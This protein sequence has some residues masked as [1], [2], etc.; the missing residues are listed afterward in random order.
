MEKGG[1]K[2]TTQAWYKTAQEPE[3]YFHGTTPEFTGF[4]TPSLRDYGH[5][6]IYFS[7]IKENG[8]TQAEYIA[9]GP[10]GGKLI[11]AKIDF[12]ILK[13]FDPRNDIRSA[14]I[15]REIGLKENFTTNEKEQVFTDYVEYPDMGD[16]APAA[17]KEGY[18]LFRVREPSVQGFS[19]AV[20]DENAIEII[21]DT[22]EMDDQLSIM[23][24]KEKDFL[25]KEAQAQLMSEKL[26]GEN[27]PDEYEIMER[28]EDLFDKY[29]MAQV[30]TEIT[31]HIMSHRLG[32]SDFSEVADYINE[33]RELEYG[34]DFE[35]I[36]T[37]DVAY[38]FQ[39]AK[40]TVVRDSDHQNDYAVTLEEVI[41]ELEYLDEDEIVD[42]FKNTVLKGQELKEIEVEKTRE[43]LVADNI[44][45][46]SEH[47]FNYMKENS[48]EAHSLRDT[49]FI[50]PDGTALSLG[51]VGYR[52]DH[53]ALSDHI[54]DME[55][56]GVE[57]TETGSRGVALSALMMIGVVRVI[58]EGPGIEFKTS[59]T[60]RQKRK[61]KDFLFNYFEN[62]GRNVIMEYPG[63]SE[64]INNIEDL[65]FRQL[66]MYFSSKN[67]WYKS[68]QL[69]M[70]LEKWRS[71]EEMKKRDGKAVNE[72]EEYEA[73]NCNWIFERYQFAAKKKK[74]W[75]EMSQKEKDV[76]INE[77]QKHWYSHDLTH[78]FDGTTGNHIDATDLK[79]IIEDRNSFASDFF[80]SHYGPD[81]I[82]SDN[83]PDFITKERGKHII[84]PGSVYGP[85]GNPTAS[86]KEWY[87]T[88][89]EDPVVDEE[90]E[91]KRKLS[92]IAKFY[93]SY[94]PMEYRGDVS[95]HDI[96]IYK[97]EPYLIYYNDTVTNT[98]F[99]VSYANS[100]EETVRV[101]IENGRSQNFP[102]KDSY[103]FSYV[104]GWY[105]TAAE[106]IEIE[107]VTVSIPKD[108]AGKPLYGFLIGMGEYPNFAQIYFHPHEIQDSP[109][110]Q[111]GITRMNL[112]VD[113]NKAKELKNA[114]DKKVKKNEEEAEE[115][116]N[117]RIEK[118][119]QKQKEIE[120]KIRDNA[121]EQG[122][123]DLGIYDNYNRQGSNVD[124]IKTAQELE[125]EFYERALQQAEREFEEDRNIDIDDRAEHLAQ[126]WAGNKTANYEL[127][128]WT[129]QS[130]EDSSVRYYEQG[131]G[132][133]SAYVNRGENIRYNNPV[134]PK[135]RLKKIWSDFAAMGFVPKYHERAIWDIKEK[136]L[137]AIARLNFLTEVQGH[138][139]SDPI[140][141]VEHLEY[142]NRIT[143]EEINDGFGDFFTDE[144]GQW[145]LSDFGLPQLM[146]LYPEIYTENDPESLLYLIDKVLNIVHQRSDLA[147]FF[148]EGGV[149][150]L[151]EIG[152][153]QEEI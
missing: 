46:Y 95:F 53:R 57:E 30:E 77:E 112:D 137:N 141:I 39:D 98:T 72:N 97:D 102:E 149:D 25:Y 133:L 128:E 126:K 85:P 80:K 132:V 48:S 89:Q 34:E 140:H 40:E 99:A 134:I 117:I 17:I 24:Q 122:E 35:Y 3:V 138:S 7:K 68:A 45:R 111:D 14:E 144:R 13:R 88:A 151:N 130:A 10:F 90:T 31:G 139:P 76:V 54:I 75:G 12:G 94:I 127:G 150:S 136:I 61:I 145:L 106:I 116:E 65:H 58:P 125:D 18:S 8:K 22:D 79:N 11:R 103:V 9:E 51:S 115:Q 153:Y 120:K 148:I 21:P 42:G 67:A 55:E 26:E 93:N 59:L 107:N 71:P 5:G 32:D 84:T 70:M 15:M 37:K 56:S 104:N 33:K 23:S 47:I 105:K 1:D 82:E 121:G 109:P 108:G 110:Y 114:Y 27:D 74:N 62:G 64:T 49:A 142:D 4:E 131:E 146:D 152:G 143:P 135:H 63:G 66:G 41:D 124:T 87:K 2:A 52:D 92:E 83:V 20:A 91:E 16:I 36:E 123:L 86:G 28:T 50:L 118:E 113:F 44:S 69:E 129:D 19:Y 60:Y 100:N 96:Q 43:E 119:R 101:K 38:L 73:E 6:V 81:T 78:V 29:K 147:A